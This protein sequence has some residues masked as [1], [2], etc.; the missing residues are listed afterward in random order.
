MI[1][2][3]LT[4]MG[5]V[6]LIKD[7]FGRRRWSGFILQVNEKTAVREDAL[8]INGNSRRRFS[9][10]IR[11]RPFFTQVTPTLCILAV[12]MWWSTDDH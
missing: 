5:V 8:P 11:R 1:R 9:P 7:E 2:H 3:A 12:S 4:H 10:G 6:G